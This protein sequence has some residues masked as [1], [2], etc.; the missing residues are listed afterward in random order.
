MSCC[1]KSKCVAMC[2]YCGNYVDS[3][4][5]GEFSGIGICSKCGNSTDSTNSCKSFEC[6]KDSK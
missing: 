4:I 1:D 6:R 3:Y 5:D 2:Y